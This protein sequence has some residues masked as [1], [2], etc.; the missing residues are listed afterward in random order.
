MPRE[1]RPV[2]TRAIPKQPHVAC[3]A[4]FAVD[5]AA[6][7]SRRESDNED[8]D[9]KLPMTFLVA[10]PTQRHRR[11]RRCEYIVEVTTHD[12]GWFQR[13]DHR[14][15]SSAPSGAG[16][17]PVVGGKSQSGLAFSLVPKLRLG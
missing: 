17:Y 12:F 9:W 2:K 11:Q 7:S 15:S 1:R 13:V 5:Q 6:N 4:G 10:G 3:I 14:R 8:A 16:G